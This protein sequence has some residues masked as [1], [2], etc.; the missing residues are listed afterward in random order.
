MIKSKTEFS[1]IA[2]QML[3]A[4][5][6]MSTKNFV[7]HIANHGIHPGE[8]LNVHTLIATACD[9]VFME[10]TCLVDTLATIECIGNNDAVR[11]QMLF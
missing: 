10:K 8:C 9:D 5:P 6:M 3:F 7:F 4:H 2:R 1:K 11:V